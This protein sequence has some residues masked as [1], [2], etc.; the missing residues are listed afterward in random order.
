MKQNPNKSSEKKR[1]RR[2][3]G[4]RHGRARHRHGRATTH[5]RAWG[6]RL[7][8]RPGTAGRASGCAFRG[9][10]PGVHGRAPLWHARAV[11]LFCSVLLYP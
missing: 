7:A 8:V 11:V 5:G 3:L 4:N 9:L 10:L 1:E 2:P 6:A